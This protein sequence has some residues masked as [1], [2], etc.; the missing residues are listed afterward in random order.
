MEI[1]RHANIEGRLAPLFGPDEVPVVHIQIRVYPHEPV[2][3]YAIHPALYPVVK[4]FLAAIAAH[5]KLGWIDDKGEWH[6]C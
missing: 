4:R 6:G 2:A 1:K 3:T 5:S